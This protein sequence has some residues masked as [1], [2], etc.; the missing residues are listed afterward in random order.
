LTSAPSADS[1]ST[2]KAIVERAKNPNLSFG[3]G[4]LAEASRA[5]GEYLLITQPRALRSAENL[6]VRE[7]AAEHLVSTMERAAWFDGLSF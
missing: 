2:T 5:F 6:L 3:R 7:P 4:I 1:V